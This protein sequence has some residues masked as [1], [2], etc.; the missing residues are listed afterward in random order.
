MINITVEGPDKSGKGHVIALIA[1]AM[2]AQGLEVRIQGEYG[3]NANKLVKVDA[4][5][6]KRLQG[7]PISIMGMQT[8]GKAVTS[9]PE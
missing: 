6:V 9:K 4:D 5:L 2:Q 8:S 7:V 3:H 1:H